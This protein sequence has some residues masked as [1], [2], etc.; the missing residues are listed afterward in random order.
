LGPVEVKPLVEGLAGCC[1]GGEEMM[2]E[3]MDIDG[4]GVPVVLVDEAV[5]DMLAKRLL[6]LDFGAGATGCGAAKEVEEVMVEVAGG[7]GD[8]RPE[9][10]VRCASV[11]RPGVVADWKSSKSSS[12]AVSDCSVLK[13]SAAL[14]EVIT[15]FPFE[16]DVAAGS[17]PKSNRSCSGSF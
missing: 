12:P 2:D 1:A 3:V 10:A 9:K 7:G 4:V 15:A 8:V 11:V 14:A 17:S 13:S 5:G 6:M 16:V